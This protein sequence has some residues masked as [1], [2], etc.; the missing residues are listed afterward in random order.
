M[1]P[2]LRPLL[3]DKSVSYEK[4]NSSTKYF[5]PWPAIAEFPGVTF[6][7]EPV[8]RRHSIPEGLPFPAIRRPK[9]CS[10]SIQIANFQMI[11]LRK[12][13]FGVYITP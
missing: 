7:L 2:R 11:F 6:E 3:V 4:T 10:A 8:H 5:L 9:A 1:G 13:M 12:Q